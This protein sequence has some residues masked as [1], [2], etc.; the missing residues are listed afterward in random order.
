MDKVEN[1]SLFST[2]NLSSACSIL[3]LFDNAGLIMG[4]C[5]SLTGGML[6][7]VFTSIPGASKTF[8]GGF[9]AYQTHQKHDIIN[10]PND[11]LQNF[12]P[13]SSQCALA[14]AKGTLSALSCDGSICTTGVAGPDRDEWG[15][16]VGT[17]FV[18]CALNDIVE[19]KEFNFDPQLSRQQ[20]R[21]TTI[22]ETLSFALSFFNSCVGP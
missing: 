18:S 13:A 12:G 5:E 10:V 19:F 22:S 11:I 4:T 6:S 7:A 17:V 2:S 14:L 3:D 9:T 20:I 16:E 8:T 1:L 15:R 21:I